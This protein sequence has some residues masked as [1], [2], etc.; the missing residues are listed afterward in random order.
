MKKILFFAV[1]AL[2]AFASCESSTDEDSNTNVDTPD[3]SVEET[4][5]S[6]SLV[7]VDYKD[8][9]I[10][11]SKGSYEG[12]F[13]V[14][15]AAAAY[16]PG[17]AVE[18][19]ELFIEDEVSYGTDFSAIDYQ[20]IFSTGGNISLS[21]SWMLTNGTEYCVAVFGIDDDGAITTDVAVVWATTIAVDLV[22]SIE[23]EVTAASTSE[24]TVSATPSA[25]VG[26]YAYFIVPSYLYT[27]YYGSDA[28]Y[29][30]DL[31][32]YSLN[33]YGYDVSENDGVAVLNGAVEFSPTYLWGITPDV[34][35]TILIFGIDSY[36]NVNTEINI[37]ECMAGVDDVSV[38]GSLNI[39]LVNSSSSA[40]TVSVEAVGDVE[41]YY[42]CPCRVEYFEQYYAE[43]LNTAAE[44]IIFEDYYYY[45]TDLSVVD[46][47][48]IFNGSNSEINLSNG[49]NF[50][51]GLDYM[52]LAFG[53]NEN[54]RLT[55][56]VAS[57]DVS[58]EQLAAIPQSGTSSLK[59][60]MRH[61]ELVRPDSPAPLKMQ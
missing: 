6:A 33:Y 14:G 57:I 55:T 31:T 30:A 56:P 2:F 60:A 13:F 61:L 43:D 35:H 54:G 8:I 3:D 20:Y 47:Q 59:G 9:T 5:I 42:V 32:V 1:A 48:Y 53:I 29:L 58:A 4:S 28:S 21:N 17:D 16:Y 36:G 37:V 19:A 46:N 7:S 34:E 51:S 12:N 41:N 23:C 45:G 18:Y 50:A 24:I 27:F 11:V 39:T 26:N 38:D 25:E 52:I 44:V 15:C 10:S 40:M 22:G 49:W